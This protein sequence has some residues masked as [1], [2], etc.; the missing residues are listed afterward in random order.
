MAV[1]LAVRRRAVRSLRKE[2]GMIAGV[3]VDVV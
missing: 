2:D 1:G 3:V